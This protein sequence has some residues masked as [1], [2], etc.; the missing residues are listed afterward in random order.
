MFIRRLVL[1]AV[2]AATL[3]PLAGCHCRRSC[4]SSGSFSPPPAPCCDKTV[5]SGFLPPAGH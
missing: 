5:P 2:A 1:A 4:G 3:V